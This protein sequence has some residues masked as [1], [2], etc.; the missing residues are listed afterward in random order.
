M[1]KRILVVHAGRYGST[2]DVAEAIGQELGQCAA[3]VEVR[4]AKDVTETSTYD[5]VIVGSPI[6]YGKWRSEAVRVLKTHEEVLSRIPVAY[7]L[8]C[9]ELTK[10]SQGQGPDV[11]VYV[12]PQLGEPPRVEGKLNYFERTH[13]LSTFLGP[14]LKEVPRVKPVSVGVFR[15]MLDYSK[16]NPIDWVVMKLIWL[17]YKKAPEG[18][19]RNWESIRSWAASL[20]PGL[21]ER[22]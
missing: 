3:G 6:Y 17:F 19:F 2:A 12:D 22:G 21:L 7:F 13:L 14:V 11:S 20:G 10:V 9:L 15:G 18:D 5:A 16:L 1:D 4:P 8:T